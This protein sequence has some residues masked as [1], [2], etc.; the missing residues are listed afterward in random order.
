[1][2]NN[3]LYRNGLNR[4]K[5]ANGRY[6]VFGRHGASGLRGL[7]RA[8]LSFSIYHLLFIISLT[9]SLP[10]SAQIKVG[11]NVYGGGNQGDV[12]GSTR[13]NVYSGDIGTVESRTDETTPIENPKGKLF[14]GARMANVGGNT[15]VNIDGENASGYVLINQVYGGNDIAGTIGENKSA[16]KVVPSELTAIKS[17]PADADPKKNAV[18]NTFNSFVRI[19]TKMPATP[20]Y[21][22]AADVAAAADNPENPAWNKTPD[23][24]LKPD[25]TGEKIYIGQL[26]G[27]GNGDYFYNNSGGTHAIYRSEVDFNLHN[28]PIATSTTDFILP[29]QKKTYL[30]VV[31]GSI[32]YGYGGGNNA[33]VKEQT[34]IHVDNPSLV[35]NHIFINKSSWLEDKDATTASE[36]IT[37]LLCNARFKEMGIN[38]GFSK[39]GSGEYQIG[40]FFGG[41]NK[42]EMAI[43]PTWN[44]VSGKIRNLYSGGNRG[45]MTS[46]EGLLL[47]IPDYSTLIADYVYGGCRMAD[48]MPTVNGEYVPCTNLQ[49]KDAGGNLKYKFPNELSARV[50]IRG[51]NINTVYGGNDVTGRVYGGN[52]VSIH[53]SIRGDVY[54]GGN[55][56]YPYT[57]NTNFIGDDVY[58]DLYYEDMSMNDFRPNAEQVSIHLKGTEAKPTVIGGSIFCGG[59]C[60]TLKSAKESPL[61]E[62]K[63]GSYVRADKAFLG[64]NGEEMIDP[65][66]LLRYATDSYNSMN[67]KDPATFKVY[68]DGA[69]MS[70]RPSVVFD[71]EPDDEETYIDYTSQIGSFYCGGNVGSMIIPGKHTLRFDRGLV[72]F[73]KLVGG[74]NNANVEEGTYNAAYKGGILGSAEEQD[75]YMEGGKIKDRLEIN[76][77]NVVIQPKR[78]NDVFTPI[79]S[80]TLTAGKTYYETA[81]RTSEFI[82]TGSETPSA[83]DPY[84]ELTTVGK[85]LEWN[86][87]KWDVD[88]NDFIRTGTTET[89]DDLERRLYGGNVYGGCFNSGHVNGNGAVCRGRSQRP[90]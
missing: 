67:L 6:E 5:R 50:L 43:R 42:A 63:I 82:A 7:H 16:E 44:L 52:A 40:R 69:A 39:P 88:E 71:Q 11:G 62:L 60:A 23:K 55:G 79:T 56:A 2:I 30:E 36:T 75:S 26:F 17:D 58:G 54:G 74:C 86:T 47:E 13:V 61:M 84:Y 59:N 1:M 77:N 70:L 27:G 65:G 80:G 41:N 64:N 4:L 32:V 21:Y 81:L 49:D 72:I 66:Y 15:F 90:V 68:M 51:G 29:E 78:W 14:G 25:P 22:S 19:S 8:C 38:T 18:D 20:E 53:T 9:C 3:K 73:E 31:G 12:N 24:D 85:E 83:S 76:L 37:D 57:D 35:T 10:A 45:N 33:T 87:V 34:I 89:S 46:P 28:S 48:V